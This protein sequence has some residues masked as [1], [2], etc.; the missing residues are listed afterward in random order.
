MRMI[1]DPERDDALLDAMLRDETWQAASA[2]FKADALR[3]FR[4]RQRLRRLARWTGSAAAVTAMMAAA[5]YGLGRH[6]TPRRPVTLAHAIMPVVAPRARQL[7]DAELV[8]AFPKGSC[9][10]AEVDGKKQL[11]FFDPKVER[12]CLARTAESAR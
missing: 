1:P 4:T 11:V 8:A 10:I 5:L 6:S 12:A 9:F 3:T 7:S 2:G